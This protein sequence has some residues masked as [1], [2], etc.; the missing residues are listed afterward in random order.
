MY[1]KCIQNVYCIST[2]FCIHFVWQLNS[3]SKM[4]TKVCPNVRFILHTICI[5]QFS[6][7]KIVYHK[8][9]VYSL[10][11]KFRHNVYINNCM[12][13]GSNISIYFDLSL[14]RFLASYPHEKMNQCLSDINQYLTDIVKI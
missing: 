12:Q 9:Y 10:Y 2:N 14:L 8:N 5:H 1:I 6:S 4:H 13:N 11:T 7:T 3:V